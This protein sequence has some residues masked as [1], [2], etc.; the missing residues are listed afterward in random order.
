MT[1]QSSILNVWIVVVLFSIFQHY[2][3]QAKTNDS[4]GLD[5]KRLTDS[6]NL[7]SQFQKTLQSKLSEA[8]AQGGAVEAIKICAKEA[9]YIAAELSKQHGVF[10]QRVSDQ[11]RNANNAPSDAQSEVLAYF[12]ANP[13]QNERIYQTLEDGSNL[14]AQA[15]TVQEPCL[16]CHGKNIAPSVKKALQATY[17]NDAATGYKK[18]DLRGMFSVTWPPA[19]AATL[20]FK[21]FK[22]VSE[23]LWVGG[24]PEA[25]DFKDL[26]ALGITHVI[27][28]RT[29]GE[30]RFDESKVAKEHGMEY[31][32]LPI[33]GG[34]DISFANAKELATILQQAQGKVLL[35]CASSNRVGALLALAA[36]AEGVDPEAALT[37]GRFSGMT[38]LE[39]KVKTEMQSKKK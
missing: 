38:R 14:F 15:I 39:E 37:L 24:Q 13:G 11:T 2:P 17:P 27:N 26:Q 36:N 32:A 34:Q 19:E 8:M 29:P 4:S 35:H 3:V 21:N 18:G 30:M 5:A 25:S 20:G 12:A 16:T 9:P 23:K 6:Q 28:L 1:P 31:R 22:M 10:V 33:A 7:V